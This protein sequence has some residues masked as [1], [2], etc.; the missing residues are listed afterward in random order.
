MYSKIPKPLSSDVADDTA[1]VPKY[2]LPKFQSAVLVPGVASCSVAKK[3]VLLPSVPIKDIAI[4][5]VPL[6]PLVGTPE[7][8]H[9]PLFDQYIML[10]YL[11]HKQN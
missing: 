5:P 3:K 9:T 6:A 11:H 7:L 10:D 8:P 1:V 4:P 2:P